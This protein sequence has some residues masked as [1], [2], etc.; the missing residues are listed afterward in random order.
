MIGS[1]RKVWPWKRDE[2]WLTHA[3]GSYVL[4]S[5]GEP[6]VTK[7]ADILPSLASSADIT[8]FVIAVGLAVI[9]FGV[10]VALDRLAGMKKV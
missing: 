7:Q 3:D 4:D 2:A 10:I 5:F 6:I 8:E 9:G 1:L